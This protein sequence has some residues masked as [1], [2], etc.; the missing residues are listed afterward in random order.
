MKT[1]IIIGLMA[2]GAF[3]FTSCSKDAGTG[4]GKPIS[5]AV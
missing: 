1:Q 2:I 5:M 4:G 3:M